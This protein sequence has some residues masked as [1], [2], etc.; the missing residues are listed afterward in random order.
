MSLLS[1]LDIIKFALLLVE[2]TLS[3]A[4]MLVAMTF[5]VGLFIAVVVGLSTG[6]LLAGKL[7]LWYGL[8]AGDGESTHGIRAFTDIRRRCGC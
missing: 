1:P 4:L 3:Y 5:N 8:S 2:T 6:S 7:R